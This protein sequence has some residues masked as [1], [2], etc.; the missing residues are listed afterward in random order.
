MINTIQ[1]KTKFAIGRALKVN[2]ID[3]PSSPKT[4]GYDGFD[5]RNWPVALYSG[6]ANRAHV[7]EHLTQF[8]SDVFELFP[9]TSI[10]FRRGARNTTL[11]TIFN[12]KVLFVI[13]HLYYSYVERA[14]S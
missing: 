14:T 4:V 7:G 5:P 2:W 10:S 11:G 8:A 3:L 1:Q 12:S 9:K 13:C 6:D